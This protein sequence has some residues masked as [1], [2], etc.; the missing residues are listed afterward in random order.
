[1]SFKASPVNESFMRRSDFASADEYAV[2]VRDHIQANMMVRCIRTYE[3]VHEGDVGR[4]VRI[5]KGSLHALNVQVKR[6]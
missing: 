6:V 3:E 4:V 5:D 2:Y 1:M